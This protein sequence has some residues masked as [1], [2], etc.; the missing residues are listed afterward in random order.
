MTDY[1]FDMQLVV[2]P[3]DENNVVRNGLI[4]IYDGEDPGG[5]V[6]LALMS[7]SGVPLPNP[8]T[9][10]VY[11]YLRPFTTTSPKARWQSGEFEGFFFSYQGLRDESIAAKDAALAAAQDAQTSAQDA[12]D[13]RT[14]AE[15]AEAAAEAMTRTV[16]DIDCG[17]P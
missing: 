3:A 13:A 8:M 17:T 16:T 6:L 15:A 10:N 9:S 1:A 5:N 12:A 11:G 14:A 4:S 2:D 7:P